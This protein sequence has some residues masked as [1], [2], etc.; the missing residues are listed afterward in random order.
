MPVRALGPRTLFL[1]A[2]FKDGRLHRRIQ[3]QSMNTDTGGTSSIG[4]GMV[5]RFLLSITLSIFLNR[6]NVKFEWVG[7]SYR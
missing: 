2:G 3:A 7:V 6:L 1:Q 4:F 5:G